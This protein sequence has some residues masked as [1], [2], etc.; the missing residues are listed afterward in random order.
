[1]KQNQ[2][3]KW[4]LHVVANFQCRMNKHLHPAPFGLTVPVLS[5]LWG[6]LGFLCLECQAQRRL[7]GVRIL[8]QARPGTAADC[9]D[10]L[11][12]GG[13]A[14]CLVPRCAGTDL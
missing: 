11:T 9:F 12:A 7:M 2:C 3:R 10:G 14:R 13:Y 5:R 8:D 6:F 1:M 4:W